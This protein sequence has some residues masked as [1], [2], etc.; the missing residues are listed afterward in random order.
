[1]IDN[2]NLSRRTFIKNSAAATAAAVAVPTVLNAQAAQRQ[3]P[4]RAAADRLHRRRRARADASRF[5]HRSCRTTARSKSPPSATCSI[6]IATKSRQKVKR[7][8][9]HKPKQTGDYRDI[10]NDHRST[11]S[12]IATPDHWHAKQTHRRA[13][14]RQARLLR[15]AD[16]AQRRGSARRLQGVEGLRPGDAGRRAV[17]LAARVERRAA[18][19]SATASSAKC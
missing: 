13:Q 6:A 12:C 3:Q 10:L 5:G 16:D 15:K 4:Q 18:S 11:P 1:M 14:G 9:K 7:G 8:T 2:S 17:D 19:A